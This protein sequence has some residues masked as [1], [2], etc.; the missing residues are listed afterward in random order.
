MPATPPL[1]P[2]SFTQYDPV[3]SL[4]H[5]FEPNLGGKDNH[6]VHL[7]IGASQCNHTALSKTA[8]VGACCISYACSLV[9][10]QSP[11][12]FPLSLQTLFLRLF[13]CSLLARAKLPRTHLHWQGIN[14]IHTLYM[15]CLTPSAKYR[16]FT[17]PSI[18]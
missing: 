2:L 5:D 8:N 7:E 18:P 14:C 10:Q 15:L 17:T 16:I 12:L 3:Y 6:D 13:T 4:V 11:A 1:F 9:R